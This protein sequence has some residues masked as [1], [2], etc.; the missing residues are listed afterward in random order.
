MSGEGESHGQTGEPFICHPLIGVDWAAPPIWNH[1]RGETWGGTEDLAQ[2]SH[3]AVT[4]PTGGHQQ[5]IHFREL[6]FDLSEPKE[7]V[8]GRPTDDRGGGRVVEEERGAERGCCCRR[9][10]P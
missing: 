4:P 8:E 1:L 3:K 6:T 2:V 9:I 5:M 10:P 7:K